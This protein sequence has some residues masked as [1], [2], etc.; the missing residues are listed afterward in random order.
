MP[1]A[2]IQISSSNMPIDGDSPKTDPNA[3][4]TPF[5]PLNERN[6]EK[7]CPRIGDSATTIMYDSVLSQCIAAQPMIHPFP[8]S[9]KSV[10]RP[11]LEPETRRTLV[12][13]TFR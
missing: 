12:N 9:P 8:M 6:G 5:P 4:A 10:N 2:P 1:T 11:A 13:P 7:I 3:V